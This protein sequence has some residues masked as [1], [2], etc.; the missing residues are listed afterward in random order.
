MRAQ[1]L[2]DFMKNLIL[3]TLFA[4]AGTCLAAK[5]EP[6]AP[7]LPEVTDGERLVL[8]AYEAEYYAATATAAV[9][10]AKADD[11]GRAYS[12]ARK[13]IEDRCAAAGAIL[14][15]AATK[16]LKCAVKPPEK[17]LIPAPSEK[18]QP[19]EKVQPVINRELIPAP[20]EK[21]LPQVR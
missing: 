6:P 12:E 2:N 13:K 4:L 18:S 20:G 21:P 7:P 17:A 11:A 16:D 8:S 9:P 14:P 10:K 3:L 5:K 15:P 19:T 1:E